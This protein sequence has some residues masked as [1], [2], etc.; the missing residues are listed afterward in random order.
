MDDRLHDLIH[1]LPTDLK[2][3]MDD[4]DRLIEHVLRKERHENTTQSA[5]QPKE[6][7]SGL[8]TK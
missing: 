7:T 2:R 8:D 6:V 1:K 4:V 3:L 5:P